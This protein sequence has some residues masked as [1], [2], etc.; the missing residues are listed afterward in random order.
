MWHI[1]KLYKQQKERANMLRDCFNNYLDLH[2][3]FQILHPVFQWE[4]LI[5][6]ELHNHL[7]GSYHRLFSQQQGK[8]LRNCNMIMYWQ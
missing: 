7:I 5:I 3:Q 6:L 4:S 2:S 1:N 8:L